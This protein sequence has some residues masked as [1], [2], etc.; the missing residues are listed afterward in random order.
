L[1]EMHTFGDDRMTEGPVLSMAS[2][3]TCL[4]PPL[5]HKVGSY[6]AINVK[7]QIDGRDLRKGVLELV[8]VDGHKPRLDDRHLRKAMRQTA[9]Q[10][11]DEWVEAHQARRSKSQ[12]RLAG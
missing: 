12:T 5:E 4:A 3:D 7:K 10:T 8:T 9:L 2:Y 6:P 1:I 11:W